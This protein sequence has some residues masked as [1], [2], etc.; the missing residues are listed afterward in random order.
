MQPSP[1]ASGG[2]ETFPTAD[3][4][5]LGRKLRFPAYGED[6]LIS[7]VLF[8]TGKRGSGKSFTAGVMMEE[9]HRLG[10]QFVC[11]DALDAHGGLDQMARVES[12]KPSEGQS[13]EMKSLVDR[14][15]TTD[16]SL[17]IKMGGLSLTKQQELTS[18]LKSDDPFHLTLSCDSAN[19]VVPWATEQRWSASDLL[20]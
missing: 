7:N 3:E 2:G 10:L 12:I 9:F 19:L 15:K 14:L 4:I 18:F 11:F 17:V 1:L 6:S 20:V 8:I 5:C 16:K 13:I